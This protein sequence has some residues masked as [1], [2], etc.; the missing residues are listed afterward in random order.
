[1]FGAGAE[2]LVGRQHVCV[3]RLP[4]KNPGSAF[5]ICNQIVQNNSMKL[6]CGLK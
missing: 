3:A 4:Y 5:M 1:M 2:S 6:Q